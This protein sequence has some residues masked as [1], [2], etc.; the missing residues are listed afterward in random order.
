MKREK[1]F[2]LIEL[3]VAMAILVVVAVATGATH[4][5][6]ARKRSRGA[7]SQR[8]AESPRRNAFPGS[9]PDASG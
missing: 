8:A 4:T 9:R 7:R 2:S 6:A 5:G 3:L 1:G